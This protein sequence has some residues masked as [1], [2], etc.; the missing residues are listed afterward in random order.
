MYTLTVQL[1]SP[2]YVARA[3]ARRGRPRRRGHTRDAA[4]C[5]RLGVPDIGAAAP[6]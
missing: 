3:A 6:S 1:Y 5:L 4:E 2:V